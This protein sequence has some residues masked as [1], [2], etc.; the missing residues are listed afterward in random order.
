MDDIRRRLDELSYRLGQARWTSTGAR[1]A[2]RR[3]THLGLL[4]T[5][6]DA[7]RAMLEEVAHTSAAGRRWS[8]VRGEFEG[9]VARLERSLERAVTR[10]AVRRRRHERSNTARRGGL[11][12]STGAG[13][14]RMFRDRT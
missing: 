6:C 8:A 10:E 4:R 13:Q 1:D 5:Q 12:A 7:L 11:R 14:R 2:A 9:A 3:R